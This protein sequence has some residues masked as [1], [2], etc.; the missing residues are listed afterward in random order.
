MF[1][2]SALVCVKGTGAYYE[3]W[4]LCPVNAV[5]A[6]GLTSLMKGSESLSFCVLLSWVSLSGK[7]CG[8]GLSV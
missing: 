7:T 2:G 6:Q 1:C 8:L 4:L 5:C 3:P